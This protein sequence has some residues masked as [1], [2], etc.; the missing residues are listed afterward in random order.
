M[1][2]QN[3]EKRDNLYLELD[4]RFE[5]I[6]KE[7]KHFKIKIELN[8]CAGLLSEKIKILEPTETIKI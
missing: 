3:K 4:K 5:V 2:L 8:F 7:K 6:E 1:N